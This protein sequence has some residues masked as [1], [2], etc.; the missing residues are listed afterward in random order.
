MVSLAFILSFRD[1]SFSSSCWSDKGWEA[2]ALMMGVLVEGRTITQDSE[3]DKLN[4]SVLLENHTYTFFSPET[5]AL[6]VCV[7]V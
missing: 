6:C 2:L 3:R 4:L 1:A 7:A 5:K